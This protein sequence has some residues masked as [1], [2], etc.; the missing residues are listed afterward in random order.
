MSILIAAL[1]LAQNHSAHQHHQDPPERHQEPPETGASVPETRTNV[2]E[3]HPNS[4]RTPPKTPIDHAAD[5]YFSDMAASRE[6]LRAESGGM[7]FS[8]IYAEQAEVTVRGYQW[9]GE[10]WFGG[11]IDRLTL[12]TEGEGGYEQ[13]IQKAEVQ[14]LWSHALDPFLNLQAGVRQDVGTGPRRSYAVL[15]VEGI[16]PYWITLEGALFLSD[17]GDLTA[18][19]E[20]SHDVRLTNR[21]I[22]QPKVEIALSAQD[23]PEQSIGGGLSEVDAGLRLGYAI[24]PRL[25]PYIG[26]SWERAVGRTARYARSFG[27]DVE[28]SRFLMGVRFWF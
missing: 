26:F 21:W 11:D 13:G 25:I 16:A 5:R 28:S 17:L 27:D 22:L 10:A 12:K 15:G 1:M 8:R 4:P 24:A 6:A 23:V 14:A 19:A 18:R 3:T 9:E 20:F 2:T 7:A